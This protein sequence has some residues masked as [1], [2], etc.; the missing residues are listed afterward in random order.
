M[1]PCLTLNKHHHHQILLEKQCNIMCN[2]TERNWLFLIAYLN[3]HKR[4]CEKSNE[5]I[6]IS[7][8]II[9]SKSSTLTKK[10]HD[11]RC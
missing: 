1:F 4:N 8:Q 10:L 3:T 11:N 9:Q 5:N 2:E 7:F 6:Q